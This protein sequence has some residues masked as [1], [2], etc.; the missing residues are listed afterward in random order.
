MTKDERRKTKDE[1]LRL[2]VR[3]DPQGKCS[4]GET[5]D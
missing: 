4:A 1:H 5:K 3:A 2:C